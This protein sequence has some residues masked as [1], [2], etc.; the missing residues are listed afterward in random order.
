MTHSPKFF[1][2]KGRIPCPPS[3]L[4]KIQKT[5]NFFFSWNLP[6]F[7]N[8][9]WWVFL[10]RW[11]WLVW[12]DLPTWAISGYFLAACDTSILDGLVY[13]VWSYFIILIESTCTTWDSLEVQNED[14]HEKGLEGQLAHHNGEDRPLS[15]DHFTCNSEQAFHACTNCRKH[16]FFW[17]SFIS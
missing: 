17:Y 15:D 3:H 12:C 8:H 16:N 7:I 11:V 4:D 6:L 2:N 9:S 1:L 13:H 14:G 5:S 10:A